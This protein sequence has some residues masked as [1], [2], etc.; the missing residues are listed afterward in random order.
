MALTICPAT[1]VAAPVEVVWDLLAAPAQWNDWIDGQVQR[2]EPAGPASPG[3]IV[4]VT[5]SGPGRLWPVHFQV[6]T[7]N[8]ARH[9]LGMCLHP[10]RSDLLP[11]PVRLRPVLP[12]RLAGLGHREAP[13]EDGRGEHRRLVTA[14]TA[15]SPGPLPG[16]HGMNEARRA[17]GSA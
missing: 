11:R 12:A 6:E 7:V 8:P 3:Q 2:I 10:A 13:G 4:T 1:R 14:S 9:Q 5:A 15:R 16:R 17:S